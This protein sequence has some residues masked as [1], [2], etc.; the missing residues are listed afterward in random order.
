M[1]KFAISRIIGFFVSC[2]LWLGLAQAAFAQ[3]SSTLSAQSKGGTSSSLP[4]AGSTELTYVLF[5][6]GA[7]L[8]VIGAV[9]LVL[10]FRD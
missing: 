1:V 9:K 8:F 7:V 5:I 3:T 6:A 10:S 2:A 4:A